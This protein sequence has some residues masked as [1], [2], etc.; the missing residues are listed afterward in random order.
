MK[1]FQYRPDVDGLRA[2]AVMLVLFFHAGLGFTGGFIGVDIFFVISGFL[3]TGLVLKKLDDGTFSLAN[4]WSR[5]IRRILP[6]ST[7]MVIVVLFCSYFLLLSPA[8]LKLGESA[9]AQQLMISN[10]YFW[11]NTGYFAGAADEKLLL[12]TWSL[13]VEEQFYL[14]YPILLLVLHRFGRKVTCTVLLL[15]AIMSLTLSE[16]A[17]TAHPV[18]NFY[19]LPTRSW[20]LII[21]GLIWFLPQPTKVKPEVLTS[22]SWISVVLM[23]ATGC[24]YSSQT[25]FPGATALLPCLCTATLIYANSVRLSVPAKIL[26]S[27]P[28]V[29]V[30]LLSYS[31]YLWHWPLLVFFRYWMGEPSPL[32]GAVILLVSFFVAILSWKYVETPI[33]QFKT[34]LPNRVSYAGA[35]ISISIVVCAAGSIVLNGGCQGKFP[36]FEMTDNAKP[37]RLDTTVAEVERGELPTIGSNSETHPKIVCWGDSHLGAVLGVLDQALK[38]HNISAAVAA[39]G[40]TPPLLDAWGERHFNREKW[41]NAVLEYVRKNEVTDVLLVARWT[42]YIKGEL[43]GNTGHILTRDSLTSGPLVPEELVDQSMARTVEALQDAGVQVWIMRQVPLQPHDPNRTIVSAKVFG[44]G[45]A[46]GTSKDWNTRR[47]H[48]ANQIIDRMESKNVRVLD[49]S[50]FCYD[51]NGFS[52]IFDGSKSLYKDDDHLSVHGA[53]YLLEELFEGFADQIK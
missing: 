20:E 6:A 11:K 4:F 18:A 3:I 16:Y 38:K 53:P 1:E 12:H 45:D 33:R 9:I 10:L 22:A 48:Q 46:I 25:P 7:V 29:F 17:V 42:A 15:L 37:M 43:D 34:N 28:F 41:K 52:R 44:I 23:I 24:W 13:A 19:L 27:G 47:H 50:P 36:E 26:A 39:R 30:G 35:F 21:G 31:L 51:E 40:G 8:Y 32:S 49:P 14:G 2:V 5:R